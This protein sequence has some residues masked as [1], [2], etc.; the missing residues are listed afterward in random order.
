LSISK[1]VVQRH[2][3]ALHHKGWLRGPAAPAIP[4]RVLTRCW[5][6]VTESHLLSIQDQEQSPAMKRGGSP[7]T[8]AQPGEP[9]TVQMPALSIRASLTPKTVNDQDR[10][11]ELIFTTGAA[12]QRYDWMTGTTYLETL[13]LDPDHVRLER[14]NE[15]GPLLDSHNSYSVTDQLG[16][17]VPGSVTLTKKDGRGLVQFSK[18]EQ[19]D[20]IWQ[21][22]MQGIIRSVSVGYLVHKYEETP[23]TGKKPAIRKAVDWEPYEVSL[24]PMPADPGARV[25]EGRTE[26][27]NPCEI[28]PAGLATREERTPV[29]TE[30]RAMNDETPSQTIVADPPAPPAQRTEA[31]EPTERDEGATG[32]RGRIQGILL[33]CRSA[34]LPQ[35][36]ADKMIADG[37]PLLDAQSRVFTE[38][39]KRDVDVPRGSSREAVI[40]TG[41][42][43]LVHVRKD[44]ENAILHRVM[45]AGPDGKG[46][47]ALTEGGRAYR[48]M[49][50]LRVAEAYLHARGVRTTGM[51]KMEL[52]GAALGLTG[53]GGMHTTSDF[54]NLLADVTNKTLRLAY[55]E[56]PQTFKTIGRQVSLPDFKPSRRIQIGDAPALLE[57]KE[58][59]EF[60]R[61]TTTDGKETYQLATFGRVFAITRQALVNDDTDAFSRISTMFG[62]SARNL[63]SDLVWAQITSNPIMGDGNALFSV[64]HKNLDAVASAI[65]VA[66]LGKGRAAMRVQTSLDG[67]TILNI[68]P[69]YL[70]VPAALETTAATFLVQITPALPA[71]VNPFAGVL[72][73]IVEP[74]LDANSAT[75]WYLAADSG[76]ID[77][78]EYAFLEGENGPMVESRIGFDIDGLEIKARHDFAAKVIDWRGLWKNPGV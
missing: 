8:L 6:G 21:D 40:V 50:L 59:G 72:Q 69:K 46:G 26:D 38:L 60:T 31:S 62:R 75:A 74:R 43:P 49:S 67:V 57:V 28:V 66:S 73:P 68:N 22:V 35:A 20:P 47:F 70:V 48:G 56:A 2:L 41:D 17:I 78:I 34:R 16:A 36:F 11:V 18:R 27:T 76:Q 65:S 45:P 42:D 9:R 64:A 63:E 5:G 15:G 19:V 52:A 4:A 77:V 53:R 14:L 3:A 39:S 7:E 61:G 24:V 23:A 71:N 33:A 55:D 25:R 58:H 29:K 10:T 12:V 13:S 54:A 44:I 1:Q 37:V 30:E 32:E 51:S